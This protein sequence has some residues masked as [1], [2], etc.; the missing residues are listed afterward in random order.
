[1]E[2]RAKKALYFRL[3]EQEGAQRR[4]KYAFFPLLS[5]VP[6][7]RSFHGGGR[8]HGDSRGLRVPK[9]PRERDLLLQSEDQSL[10]RVHKCP[11]SS[12]SPSSC[13]PSSRSHSCRKYAPGTATKS[14]VFGQK[15]EQGSPKELEILRRPWRG[16]GV[17]ERPHKAVCELQGASQASHMWI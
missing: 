9:T 6:A 13:S 2:E 7:P 17:G 14:Q 10:K 1:M 3:R 5:C 8:G 12:S 11:L 4:E 15:T 16:R